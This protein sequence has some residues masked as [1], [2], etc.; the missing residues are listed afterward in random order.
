MSDPARRD[1]TAGTPTGGAA[2]AA[3]FRGTPPPA[4]WR[5]YAR[6]TL[7]GLLVVLVGL[8]LLRNSESVPVDFVFFTAEV[9]LFVALG[10]TFALGALLGASGVWFTGRR[11]AK[12]AAQTAKKK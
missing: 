11:R 2:D 6:F 9:P 3:E 8:L 4:D 5:R 12:R 7:W 1:G 10:L